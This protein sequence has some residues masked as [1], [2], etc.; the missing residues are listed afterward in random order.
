MSELEDVVHYK[1]RLDFK[2]IG[3][4]LDCIWHDINEGK[5]DKNGKF[6]KAIKEVKDKHPKPSE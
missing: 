4:Q 1:R 6:Y 3:E 5:L 2:S